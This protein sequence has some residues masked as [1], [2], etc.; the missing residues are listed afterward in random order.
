MGQFPFISEEGNNP[1]ATTMYRLIALLALVA[2]AFAEPEAEP[3][4]DA[5]P[6]YSYGYS[7]PIS[8]YPRTYGYGHRY[9]YKREAE[10]EPK[11]EAEPWY[12]YGYSGLY[13]PYTYGSYYPRTYG[14]GHRHLYK[15]EAEAEPKSEADPQYLINSA[16]AYTYPYTS[17]YH[18]AY[19]YASHYL[20]KREAEAEAE[21]DPWYR[22]GYG[23]YSRPYAYGGYRSY[24][25]PS[26]YHGWY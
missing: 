23:G 22:Y 6:W 25:Y 26:R 21:A 8:Y 11:A 4:A 7:G 24:G 13:R 12:S 1:P 10:A 19:T 3:K 20:Y 14:Y 2:C 18:T 16:Y 9:L 17:T 15:R 5:E